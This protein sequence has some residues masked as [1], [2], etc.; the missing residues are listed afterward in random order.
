MAPRMKP[1]ANSFSALSLETATENTRD[2]MGLCAS[3]T[4][5]GRLVAANFAAAVP[6]YRGLGTA[7]PILH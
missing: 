2:I 6:E 7:S 3:L 5:G 1:C 4:S